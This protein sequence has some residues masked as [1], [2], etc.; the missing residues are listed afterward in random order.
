MWCYW[1]FFSRSYSLKF[2]VSCWTWV[3]ETC[4]MIHLFTHLG[5][6]V[7]F[8]FFQI[9]ILKSCNELMPFLGAMQFLPINSQNE[10]T[11][12]F[13]IYSETPPYWWQ[14]VPSCCHFKLGHGSNSQ[15]QTGPSG[16]WDWRDCSEWNWLVS[17]NKTK[18]NIVNQDSPQTI[19]KHSSLNLFCRL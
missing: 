15:V 9:D 12:F 2:L 6:G 13:S 19:T 8:F 1:G 16:E 7:H 10:F 17:Q 4:E 3:S 18:D 14:G 11:T 5:Q